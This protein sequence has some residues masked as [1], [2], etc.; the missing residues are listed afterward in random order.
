MA[1]VACTFITLIFAMTQAYAVDPQHAL[2][3]K[4]LK[5]ALSQ[6]S[7]PS[8][9]IATTD[10]PD[11]QTTIQQ[12]LEVTSSY[13]GA[14][15]PGER[16]RVKIFSGSF[17]PIAANAFT[18]KEEK[19]AWSRDNL[20]DRATDSYYIPY[21][22]W[23]GEHWDGEKGLRLHKANHKFSVSG[24]SPTVITGPEKWSHPILKKE[25]DIYKRKK[26]NRDK[27]QLFIF[28]PEGIGRIFDRRTTRK[29]RLYDG[30][31]VKFPAGYN[32]KIGRKTTFPFTYWQGGYEK[33][34]ETAI[35]ITDIK[36]S[37][38]GVLESMEYKYYIHGRH[39]H[40]YVFKPN[41]G[42]AEARRQR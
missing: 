19:A 14:R 7:L 24:G 20:Y 6:L 38:D 21:E 31:S 36:F 26:L 39:D 5:E 3:L 22:L 15:S 30:R 13:I 41:E 10:L 40:T 35:I 17:I 27:V 34:A 32:W 4:M 42:M 8:H 2:Q 28:K 12:A 37:S 16:T 25:F 29:A 11:I 18:P 33:D 23:T 9:A 1:F